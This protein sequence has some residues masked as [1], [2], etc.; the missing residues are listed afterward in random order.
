MICSKPILYGANGIK[1]K[2]GKGTFQNIKEDDMGIFRKVS[3]W[4]VS[5]GRLKPSTFGNT[6]YRPLKRMFDEVG[7]IAGEWVR[8]KKT[9]QQEGR[10]QFELEQRTYDNIKNSNGMFTLLYK[11]DSIEEWMLQKLSTDE[12]I[13]TING[14]K[15]L[16]DFLYQNTK[17]NHDTD[18]LDIIQKYEDF[19][20]ERLLI[21]KGK[22]K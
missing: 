15:V 12:Q 18:F 4:T 9:K 8:G 11:H 2:D 3:E 6:F 7:P 1:G 10:C 22:N 5:S 19:K 14:I 20:Q 21:I 16:G 13:K 17:T